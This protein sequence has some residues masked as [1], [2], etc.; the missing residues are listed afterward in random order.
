MDMIIVSQECW[1]DS[2]PYFWLSECSGVRIVH[3]LLIKLFEKIQI[4]MR[5]EQ[6]S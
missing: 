6:G 4:S 1:G 2:R 3:W 5:D